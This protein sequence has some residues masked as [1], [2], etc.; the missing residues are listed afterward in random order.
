[1]V[2]TRSRGPCSSSLGESDGDVLALERGTVELVNTGSG[3]FGSVHLYETETSRFL[4]VG[5]LHDFNLVDL[6]DLSE[7]FLQDRDVD[8]LGKPTD[9]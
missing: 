1:V 8:R 7:S 6:S 3:V 4:G 5:I 2:L 9:V